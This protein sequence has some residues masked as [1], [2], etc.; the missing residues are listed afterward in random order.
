M[1]LAGAAGVASGLS[2]GGR[3]EAVWDCVSVHLYLLEACNL[4]RREHHHEG[5]S[6]FGLGDVCF[7]AGSILDVSPFDECEHLTSC[8]YLI[9]CRRQVLGSYFGLAGLQGLWVNYAD[10]TASVLWLACS[11]IES[12]VFFY[13]MKKR[14]R[15]KVWACVRWYGGNRASG[16]SS[17]FQ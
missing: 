2:D 15:K 1:V 4:M 7:L 12:G 14:T 10:V 3:E 8:S 17:E 16:A 5:C 11:L 13:F 9:F 6:F